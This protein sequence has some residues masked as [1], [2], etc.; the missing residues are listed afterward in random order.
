MWDDNGSVSK[1]I[2]L[3]PDIKSFVANDD[4]RLYSLTKLKFDPKTMLAVLYDITFATSLRTTSV[5]GEH[6]IDLTGTLFTFEDGSKT[7]T[8]TELSVKI[9]VDNVALMDKY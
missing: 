7:I 1:F 8:T 4:N 2:D 5:S 3:N 6:K 9:Q